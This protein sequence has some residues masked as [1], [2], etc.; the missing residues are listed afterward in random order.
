[1]GVWALLFGVGV[2]VLL[3]LGVTAWLQRPRPEPPMDRALLRSRARELSRHAEAARA[4]A[5]R[6]AAGAAEASARAASAAAARDVDRQVREG[7]FG[8][9][10]EAYVAE[11][12]AAALAD[13]AVE[14]TTEA[15]RAL[16]AVR[17]SLPAQR[18]RSR[19]TKG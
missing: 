9:R 15:H 8:A 4:A 6:A 18:S 1:M 10:Q 3:V 11:V 14:A 13:E 17:A 5:G 7:A 19:R 2:A 16:V 12:A